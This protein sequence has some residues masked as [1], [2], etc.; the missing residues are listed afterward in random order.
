MTSSKIMRVAELWRAEFLGPKFMAR[1]AI[2]IS[3]CFAAAHL[4]GLRQFTS[5]LNGTVGSTKFGWQASAIFGVGYV[6]LYLAFRGLPDHAGG[7]P[8]VE[9]AVLPREGPLVE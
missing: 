1:T 8:I 9:Q 6:V 7:E 3:A 2:I 4:F 5:I